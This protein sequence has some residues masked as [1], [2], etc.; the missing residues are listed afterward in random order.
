MSLIWMDGFDFYGPLGGTSTTGD[1]P[2]LNQLLLSSGYVSAQGVSS[3]TDTRTGYGRSLRFNSNSANSTDY[4]IT[5]AF[6][7][8]DE[9]ITGFAFK[10]EDTVLDRLVQF[11]FDNRLGTVTTQMNVYANA[12]GGLSLSVSGDTLLSASG[13]NVIFP[14]VWH[15]LE[16]R[17]RPDKVA[18]SIV[19]KI[20]GQTCLQF[21]G[22]TSSLLVPNQ[23]NM[24]RWGNYSDD[25]FNRKGAVLGNQWIDDMY[26]LDTL[27]SGFNSFLGDVVV[28]SVNIVSDQGP[29]DLSQFGGYLGH[30][31]SLNQVPTDED[32][33]YLYGNTALAR[34]M[35]GLDTLPD[36]IIDVL[37]M[38]VHVRGRKDAPGAAIIKPVMKYSTHEVSG[39]SVP[40]A[41]QYT[42]K[43]MFLEQCP[44]G[45]AWTKSKAEATIVGFEV[46]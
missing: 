8:K 4:N 43:N 17:Y 9:I 1:Y 3:L 27:G 22:V 23:V 25:Y 39:L 29:N 30:Y 40:L 16:I 36:N 38:S 34:E 19:L 20:D 44:D 15:Y 7:P 37:A 35:F 21:N 24:I 31:T 5:L 46:Q 41:V 13:P 32:T 14:N 12:E 45:T 18:G 10:Y 26:V 42:T 33:S 28:H 6:E 2:A 11:K